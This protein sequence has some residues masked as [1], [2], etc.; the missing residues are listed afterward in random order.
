[1]QNVGILKIQL[2]GVV[3]DLELNILVKKIENL[4]EKWKVIP[5][6]SLEKFQKL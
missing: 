5:I 3:K 4:D 2:R 1:M 6:E